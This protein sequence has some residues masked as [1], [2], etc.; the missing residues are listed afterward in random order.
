ME[1]KLENGNSSLIQ[2]SGKIFD[3]LLNKFENVFF[4]KIL[5]DLHSKY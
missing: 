4:F 2:K 1:S 5:N 3:C